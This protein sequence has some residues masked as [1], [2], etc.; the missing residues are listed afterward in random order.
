[1]PYTVL[2]KVVQHAYINIFVNSQWI[3]KIYFL[4]HFAENLR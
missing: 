4:V 3:F 2:Q 1:M